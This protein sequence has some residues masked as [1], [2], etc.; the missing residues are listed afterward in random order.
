VDL[1][2]RLP[3]LILTLYKML[4]YFSLDPRI[5]RIKQEEKEA[6]A[7]KKAAKSAPAS[8]TNTPLIGKSKEEEEEEKRKKEEEEKVRFLLHTP[9]Y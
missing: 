2:L 7:L 6:R 4:N 1:A 5:K 3:Q 8:G 9:I